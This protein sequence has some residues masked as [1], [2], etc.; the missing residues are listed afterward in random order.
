MESH[1]RLVRRVG[2]DDAG[3]RVVVAGICGCGGLLLEYSFGCF[4]TVTSR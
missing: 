1:W 4:V 3:A 2:Y